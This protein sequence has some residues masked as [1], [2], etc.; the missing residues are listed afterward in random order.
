MTG[1]QTCALPISQPFSVTEQY[2][3]IKGA[4]VSIEDTIRGFKMIL[5]GT[6]D[7]LPE[8]VFMNV[9]TIEEAI[10]KGE[11]LQKEMNNK[12]DNAKC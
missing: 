11:K 1:V 4:I 5:D 6:V 9:G 10:E 3:G 2:T 7:Y 12:G 8:Q